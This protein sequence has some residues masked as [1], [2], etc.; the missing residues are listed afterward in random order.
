MSK[1]VNYVP[2]QLVRSNFFVPMTKSVHIWVC[3]ILVKMPTYIGSF[4]PYRSIIEFRPRYQYW[5]ETE[6]TQVSNL[7][8]S[9]TYFLVVIM[10]PPLS[11]ERFRHVSQNKC[12]FLFFFFSPF[13]GSVPPLFLL[14]SFTQCPLIHGISY[15]S[16]SICLFILF[17]SFSFF[18]L[19]A[20]TTTTHMKVVPIS[21]ILC[22][23]FHF[24]I[25]II[26]FTFSFMLF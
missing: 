11:L 16:F 13:H 25:I 4:Q 21:N 14:S 12:P 18:V 17:L 23:L 9:M 19:C 2:Y 15:V 5:T 3:F 22:F 26:I 20:S 24:I 6:K 1:G 8:L 7:K 10:S